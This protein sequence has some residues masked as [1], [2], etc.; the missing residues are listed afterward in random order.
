MVPAHHNE[1]NTVMVAVSADNRRGIAHWKGRTADG[2]STLEGSHLAFGQ[3][4][5]I[6]LHGA[7][8]GDRHFGFLTACQRHSL[9]TDL[10]RRGVD[11]RVVQEF[12]GHRSISSTQVYTH[13]TNSQLKDIHRKLYK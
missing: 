13:V 5:Q 11:I 3:I 6:D 7:L 9:A 4:G 2:L 12:L 8:F 1:P 10:L